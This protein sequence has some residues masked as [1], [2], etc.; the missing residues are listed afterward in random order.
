MSSLTVNV[1]PLILNSFPSMIGLQ[2]VYMYIT[3]HPPCVGP[4]FADFSVFVYIYIRE[5]DRQTDKHT[6]R[7]TEIDHAL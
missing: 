5:R 2:S 1:S 7:Q 4:A 3:V 6:E